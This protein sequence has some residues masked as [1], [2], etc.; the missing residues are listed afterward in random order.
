[1]FGSN[2][3]E[4]VVVK[5]NLVNVRAQ[6]LLHSYLI[7]HMP[8][9]N[10]CNDLTI[11]AQERRHAEQ[12]WRSIDI[13]KSKSHKL[14]ANRHASISNEVAAVLD[15]SS[16]IVFEGRTSDAATKNRE[17]DT[18]SISRTKAPSS[19]ASLLCTLTSSNQQSQLAATLTPW[20]Q[21]ASTKMSYM[22]FSQ[23]FDRI[24]YDIV[25]S[26]LRDIR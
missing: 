11:S 1:M 13:I 4:H 12:C 19:L 7:A 21:Q 26:T 20:Q 2:L 6:A 23:E 17:F 16:D 5:E 15:N 8:K 3:V 9:L 25:K 22:D 14:F 24:V 10:Q 18:M